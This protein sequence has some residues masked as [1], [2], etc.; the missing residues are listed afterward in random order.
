MDNNVHAPTSDFAEELASV[1]GGEGISKCVQCGLCTASC[2]IARA[3]DHYH[4]RR[5]IQKILLGM[6]D[7]VLNDTQPWL[8]MTCRL[9]EER[10][11][12][13]ASPAEI[14]HAVRTIAAREGLVPNSFK[15]AAEKVL[16]DG[17]MLNDAYTDFE[18]DSRADLGLEPDLSWNK[19]FVNRLRQR[20]FPEGVLT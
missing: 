3:T 2:V 8:C 13:G 18:Q 12:E 6:R 4:P 10:C 20:Y 16:K 15:R 14:F 1:P 11:Q 7:E 19:T 5:L 17:W 9:C